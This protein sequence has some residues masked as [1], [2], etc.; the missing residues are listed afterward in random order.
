M[1]GPQA[2]AC[3][4]G[5][6]PQCSRARS[7]TQRA[8]RNSQ[9]RR[10]RATLHEAKHGGADG[11]ALGAALVAAHVL[12]QPRLIGQHGTDKFDLRYTETQTHLYERGS[13]RLQRQAPYRTHT[14]SRSTVIA[15]TVPAAR[16]AT[17]IGVFQRQQCSSCDRDSAGLKEHKNANS[18]WGHSAIM[19]PHP[20]SPVNCCREHHK[21]L[22][23]PIGLGVDASARN[24]NIC[25]AV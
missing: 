12:A 16:R 23:D 19:K 6:G 4:L 11:E 1:H 25:R 5:R 8:K 18:I 20:I 13:Q 10:R 3:L 2:H 24:A 14:S 22:H 17:S 7:N 9:L 21:M 15:D